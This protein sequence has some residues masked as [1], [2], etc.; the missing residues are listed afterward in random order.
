MCAL[1]CVHVYGFVFLCSCVLVGVD[2]WGGRGLRL[3]EQLL[4]VLPMQK[5]EENN[6]KT[7][8]EQQKETEHDEK[9]N[10]WI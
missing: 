6:E 5:P 1:V 10:V 3:S 8:Q 9:S 4:Q 7:N 2:G